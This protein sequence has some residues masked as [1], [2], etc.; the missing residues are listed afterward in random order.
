MRRSALIYVRVSSARQVEN[1]SLRVQ[2]ETCR[3]YCARQGWPVA[4]VFREEGE[5][6]KT[7]DRTQ[8]NALLDYVREHKHQ[9]GAVVVH[10]LSRWSRDTRD[11]YALTGLLLK[12]GIKLHS[13][14]EPISDD[15]AG[16]LME[17]VIAGVAKFENQLRASRTTG[18]MR[19]ALERGRWVHRAPLGY[20][21]T[22]KGNLSGPSLVPNPKTADM[23]RTAFDLYAR[24]ATSERDVQRQL[25]ARGYTMPDGKPPSVQTV[26]KV[27][28]NP[29]YAGYV[30]LASW[31]V[32]A[33]GDFEPLVSEQV[34]SRVQVRL[35]GNGAPR[36]HVREHDDFP[37][38]TF[39][40][41]G[42]CNHP[43]TA[44]WARGKT[45]RQYAYYWCHNR[46][47]RKVRVGRAELDALFVTLL[48]RLQ[49]RPEYMRLFKA[50]VL[51]VW[52][53][54]TATVREERARLEQRVAD[55]QR[56]LDRIADLLTD[57][58]LDPA[59]YQR[60]RERCQQGL[61]VAEATLAETVV[62]HLDVEA[63]LGYAETVLC[64]ASRLWEHASADH[65]RRLQRT[66]FPQGVV[67]VP[68]PPEQLQTPATCLAFN[69]LD[70][71]RAVE[72]ALVALRGF[73]PRSDG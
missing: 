31:G 64:D 19:K 38:R 30:R 69:G 39:V 34:F 68:G 71:P 48:A 52:R 16:Q 42:S 8:L 2:E 35:A 28:R 59:A 73:E 13:A 66:L 14:T 21:N 29:A 10:A 65:K 15:P 67:Y 46:V 44:C 43:L 3:A 27:L 22:G 58:M 25:V 41:C 53:K 26:S 1:F 62:E 49:P 24:G 9:V 17:A 72:S 20:L 70:S 45:G 32:S 33:R 61:A 11:H 12:W 5:S 40:R 37:L 63:T 56:K 23:V 47:C 7:A 6:A 50:I 60:Q 54:R 36:R 55:A 4:R 57:G 18:G 51:D